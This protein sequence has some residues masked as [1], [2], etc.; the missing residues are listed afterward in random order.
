MRGSARTGA[1]Q[2]PAQVH[3]G[4]HRPSKPSYGAETPGARY[5]LIPGAW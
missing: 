2:H 4:L 3:A 5:A 1:G